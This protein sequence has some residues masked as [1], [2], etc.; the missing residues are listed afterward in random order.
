MTDPPVVIVTGASRGL[1]AAVANAWGPQG[2]AVVLVA[3]SET[4]LADRRRIG[5]GGA[6]CLAVGTDVADW[7][8]CARVVE[9]TLCRFGRI[10]ALVN[11]AG[12]VQPLATTA[13]AD[14]E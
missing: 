6:D 8:A 5:R 13:G 10:D 14:P 9:A 11:N 2:A 7:A 4:A 3:R 1:G 12:V